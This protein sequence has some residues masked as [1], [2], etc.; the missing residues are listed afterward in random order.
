MGLFEIN[1]DWAASKNDQVINI[2]K[3]CSDIIVDI[4]I[5]DLEKDR[6]NATDYEIT[7]P[8]ASIGCRLRRDDKTE[9][10]PYGYYFTNYG[11]FTIRSIVA[12]GAKTE[13]TKIK[14][15]N[16]RWYLYG[17][18]DKNTIDRWIWIDMDIFRNPEIYDYPDIVNQYNRDGRSAFNSWAVIRLMHQ[19][20]VCVMRISDVVREYHNKYII[21][22]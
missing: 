20:P 14:E 2:I 22:V 10:Y 15:G 19:S 4:N 7:I 13:Y 6:K 17:W 12:S 5:A 11:D 1:F 3:K 16:P 8:G 18:V 9:Q 21:G